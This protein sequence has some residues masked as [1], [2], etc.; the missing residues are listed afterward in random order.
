MLSI[1][2]T[3]PGIVHVCYPPNYRAP[4]GVTELAALLDVTE[5][6]IHRWCRGDA[7]PRTARLAMESAVIGLIHCTGWELAHFAVDREGVGRLYIHNH[8]RGF[9]CSQ[10]E[11][12]GHVYSHRDALQR[13][14]SAMEIK[15][16]LMEAGRQTAAP[17]CRFSPRAAPRRPAP[18][19]PRLL[20]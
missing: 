4:I 1:Q 19:R 5:N 11:A 20:G 12:W 7:I 14:L 8:A 9:A 17:A 18:P 6:T 10:V 13:E 2:K 15:L 3:G 16:A